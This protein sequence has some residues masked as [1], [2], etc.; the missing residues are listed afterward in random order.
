MWENIFFNALPVVQRTFNCILF[1]ICCRSSGHLAISFS[2][3]GS[4]HFTVDKTT[5]TM[6]ATAALQKSLKQSKAPN[7]GRLQPMIT[8]K[9]SRSAIGRFDMS[10]F[11]KVAEQIENS[12]AFPSIEWNFDEGCYDV[13]DAISFE[14]PAKRSCNGL[15]RS[16]G[17][18]DLSSFA[19][20]GSSGS[21]C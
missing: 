6:S 17:S 10:E 21:L 4:D 2:L 18:A 9:R 20:S 15:V 16:K 5:K 1:L 19:R 3:W 14:P 7:T 12:I 13:E 11:S 8:M